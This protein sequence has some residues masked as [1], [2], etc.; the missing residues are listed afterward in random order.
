[1]I[2]SP[3]PR[4]FLPASALPLAYFAG[5]HAALACAFAVL[6][7]NPDL[8]GGFFYHPRV[9]ALVHLVTVGW[10][11]GSILGA[12]YIVAPLALRLAMPV[13]RTDWAA[14][15]AFQ[16][17]TIGMAAHFWRGSY[18]GMAWA[19]GLVWFAIAWVG[20][21]AARG[22]P[23]AVVPWAIKLHVALAFANILAAAALGA[24]IGLDRT[25]G[26]LGWPPFAA[27]I[28]HAHLAAVGWPAMMVV[29]LSYRLIPMMLPAAMPAGASLAWS[30]VLIEAGL[31]VLVFT[32]LSGA[33]PTWA[34]VLL[35]AAGLGS[36]V[37]QVRR[38]LARRM[39][40]PPALPRLDWSMWQTRA[41]LLWLAGATLLGLALTAG[42]DSWAGPLA[43]WYGIAGLIGFL[44]QIV[45]GMQGRLVP[46][47]AW[48]RAF[49]ARGGRPPARSAHELPSPAFARIIFAAWTAG[50][51]LLGAGLA[52]DRRPLVAVASALMLMGVVTGALYLA[53][54]VRAAGRDAPAD[55]PTLRPQ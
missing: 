53:H 51:P 35:I 47:Y 12:F 29:G 34:G 39:P 54:M 33:G 32:L 23:G 36:F 7:I 20:L 11:S 46:M 2:G 41:A 40:R 13:G 1:M 16:A 52:G 24:L 14:Y 5:A 48:Y 31:A 25:R 44:S 22:L 50:V 19:A 10:L 27:A 30:A 26:F 21:R 17:G 42:P 45:V 38:T 37:L 43:W 49:A 8:P 15:A 9:V 4:A 3:G 6:A 55:S 28:A 18:D